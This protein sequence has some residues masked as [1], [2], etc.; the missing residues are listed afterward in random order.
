MASFEVAPA[1]S[2]KSASLA[3]SPASLPPGKSPHGPTWITPPE[4]ALKLN[5]FGYARLMYLASS[6]S[7]AIDLKL[8]TKS[9]RFLK[10]RSRQ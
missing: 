5:R 3:S 1:S 7:S 10:I 4:C 8:M 2:P 9:N 6:S